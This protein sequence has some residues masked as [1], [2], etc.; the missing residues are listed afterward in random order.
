MTRGADVQVWAVV[1][2]AGPLDPHE[3]HQR[4][5]QALGA[6]A[7]DLV[8][9]MA[10]LPRNASGKVERAELARRAAQSLAAPAGRS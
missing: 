1:V 4:C 6:S 8:F 10:E 3:F 7:P 5:R 2:P 9:H